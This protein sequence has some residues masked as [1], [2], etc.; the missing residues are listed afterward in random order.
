MRPAALFLSLAALAAPLFSA[1]CPVNQPVV[2]VGP[3]N[4][5]SGFHWPAPIRPLGDACLAGIMVDPTDEKIWYAFGPNG[6]YQTRN[7]GVTWTHP[8]AGAVNTQ[9]VYLVP[10]QPFLVYA[11]AGSKLFL[12]RDRG[13]HWTVIGTFPHPIESV[14]AVTGGAGR[15]LVGLGWGN[16][17]QPNG[18]FVSGNLG[19]AFWQKKTFPGS[20][21]D[22]LSWDIERDPADGTLYLANEIGSHLQPYHPPFYR[23]QDNGNSWQ[24]AGALPWHGIAIQVRPDHFV[25]NLLEGAGLRTSI[26]HGNSWQLPAQLAG[27]SHTLLMDPQ[28]PKRLFGGRQHLLPQQ[29]GQVEVKGGAFV[30]IDA[31]Q[32]FKPIGLEGPT[33]GGLS[34]NGASTKLY[35]AVYASGIYVSPIPPGLLP[36]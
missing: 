2:S 6:L 29:P 26:D 8:L 22:L 11:G 4:H 13:L 27:P 16:D 21:K 33:T 24:N 3:A 19:G 15:V 18:V 36:P 14:L 32:S 31:G 1:I 28:H 20:P 25:Y 10:S 30:S 35:V 9:G 23:S 5:P 7:G 12:T 34:L 17:P